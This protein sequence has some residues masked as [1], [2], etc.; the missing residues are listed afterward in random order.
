MTDSAEAGGDILILAWLT[1]TA[2]VQIL[3]NMSL[4]SEGL[5]SAPGVDQPLVGAFTLRLAC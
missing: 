5:L 2:S 4:D 1:S 3:H